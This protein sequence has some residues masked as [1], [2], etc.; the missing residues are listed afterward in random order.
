MEAYK[1]SMYVPLFDKSKNCVVKPSMKR[2]LTLPLALSLFLFTGITYG[3]EKPS[4]K[5]SGVIICSE[6][7]I[8]PPLSEIVREHPVDENMVYQNEESEDREGRKPQ[9]FRFSPADGYRFANDTNSMQTRMGDVAGRAPITNWPGQSATGFRPM[10]PNGAA[11]AI[12]YL[13][14]INSTTFRIYNKTTGAIVL[15]STLGNLWSPATPNSGD[16]VVLYDKPADRWLLA[17]FGTSGNKIYI[18]VS[19]TNDPTGSYYTYTFTS[20]Q[21]PDYL[22]FSV[23]PDGYYMT[24]NQSSQKVFAFDRTA[25][26]AGNPSS[27]A[28]YAGFSPPDGSG[29][30]APLPGDASDGILP[31]YGTPCPIFSYSDNGWG[32]GF[33]DAV[34]IYQM[35]VDWVPATPTATITLAANVPTAA[36]DATYNAS[37]NDCVQPGTTQKLD[38]I[39]GI[40]M[41]RAQFK[42][43]SGYNSVVLNWA[44]QI[45]SSQRSI[46]WCELRQS[47]STGV[48][49]MYQEGIYVPDASTRW[50][51]SI[52]MD[53]NGSIALAYMKSDAVSI[54]PGLYYTG[55]RVCDPLGTLPVTEELG[56]AGG[57]YQTGT[58]RDGDYSD[59]VLDPD[60][61]TYWFTSEYMAGPSGGTAAKTQIFSF[62]LPSC[63]TN[64]WV[65]ISQTSGTN[66][67]CTGS[68]VTFTATPVNGGSA[69][70]YQ[71]KVDGINAGSNSSAFTTSSLSNGQ[72]VT[73]V[74]TSNL[75]GVTGNPAT[76]NA[77]TMLI[78]PPVVPSVTVAVTGGSNP[79]CAG[80]NITF[81]ATP[82]NG[83]TS[84][85]FQWKVNGNNAG[86][87]S[88]TFSSGLLTHGQ[89]VTC[90]LT[91]SDICASPASV[92][93]NGITISIN[94]VS[95]PVV[96]ITQSS[97]SNPQCNGSGVSFTASYTQGSNPSYQWKVDGSD[98]G[99]N[100]PTYTTSSLTNNQ[101]IRCDVT[102]EPSCP[103]IITGTLGSGTG[104]N[105][106]TSDQGA[107]YP[108]Y[109][110]N[111]RQQYLILATELAGMGLSAGPINSIAFDVAGNT[112][113]PA[114]L[115][116]YTI[117]LAH[118]T[119]TSITGGFL[120]GT[121][122]T[123]WGPQNYTPVV[124]SL[125]SHNFTTPFIWDGSSNM[126]VDICF[127][128]QV[129]GYSS[130][131]TYQT[132]TGFTSSVYYQRD[133]TSG[134]G[135][136]T[137]TTYSA[138]VAVRPN[139]IFTSGSGISTVSSNSIVMGVVN[140]PVINTIA[141]TSGPAGTSVT[142]N[143][144]GFAGVNA[145]LF[146]GI[147]SVSYTVNNSTQITAQVPSTTTGPVS[148]Q[149]TACGPV[150]GPVFTIT[151]AGVTLNLRAFIQGYYLGGSTMAGVLTS[152]VCDT[153]D[154]EIASPTPPNTI[155]DSDI[156][157]I[158]TSGYGNF[159]FNNLPPGTNGYI[160]LKHRNAL[161]T[162]SA[163]PVLFNTSSISYD[164]ST[165]ASQ[166]FGSNM[167]NMGD[168][169]FAL[170][171]G[172]VNK[173]G[174]IESN[175]FSDIENSSQLFV[176]G[177]VVDDLTGDN[178][179]ESS[180]YSLI[181]NNAQLFLF[182]AR[183]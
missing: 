133:G 8:T 16:P 85:S 22:K 134:A 126:V 77:I 34:N 161:E 51:G 129:V 97:G 57:G 65:N 72:V 28:V 142:I 47:Q 45:S 166:A 179:V 171:S 103:A 162:W 6:F 30:F 5:R 177:Y 66:P 15:T 115:N 132:T 156:S 4:K 182:V 145:V 20:P 58:N 1:F 163:S 63:G 144:T 67:S 143:G 56:I 148:V 33:S 91:S 135:A 24:S 175:D 35:A 68:S 89:V 88:N 170:Y 26:L 38:G 36:F 71:W 104:T 84:P 40:C 17:Q 69:P 127:S 21:F 94:P 27:R 90:V 99:T 87:N 101:V 159:V 165:A 41:F 111:G 110:G 112:G 79:S 172:D 46:K 174:I 117:N 100:S 141:P 3:K 139:M 64:A 146:N 73:C 108:T 61:V 59:L 75:P 119:A 137:S 52:A 183:P 150:N 76:S 55:R 83:G 125:N 167:K 124:N 93:S 178:I 18:A 7:H 96:T 149:T 120:T 54:Y 136:C 109:Y 86:T 13:Q 11:N 153:L 121:F 155:L 138:R 43:W 92:T 123:V 50:M 116:G 173:D 44:V 152:S 114:T 37:W 122:T 82:V 29:F 19:V 105:S 31:P 39:G 53:N 157:T 10:D 48:W 140:P 147:P 81:T 164:F 176:F 102:L 95:N 130:Y 160:V 128:N 62:Q 180:D 9:K 2:L 14:M 80:Q 32:S 154:V 12:Y 158:S 151:G 78:N 74:M 131:Q 49:S 42:P 107:A 60:G 106:T 118:T 181:E 23:W 113:N 168:G 70:S 25:M 169:K 98:V